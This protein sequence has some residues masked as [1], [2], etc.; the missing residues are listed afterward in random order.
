MFVIQYVVT[1][2]G[3]T[4]TYI[5]MFVLLDFDEQVIDYATLLQIFFA[6]HDPTTLNRQG[7]D[8][9][10]QYR[11]VI[12]YLDQSQQAIATAQIQQLRDQGIDVVTELAP[13]PVFYRAEDDHQNFYARHPTQ[14]YCNA[15]I[16]PKLTKLNRYFIDYLK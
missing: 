10:T 3:S 14:G 7:N 4:S 1:Q 13:A 5:H 16:P 9:G 11:S 6:T 12:F 15:V 8:V 2:I